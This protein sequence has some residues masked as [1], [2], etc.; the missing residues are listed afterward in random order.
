M[1]RPPCARRNDSDDVGRRR[2]LCYRS[3]RAAV[4]LEVIKRL[5]I[6]RQQSSVGQG[7]KWSPTTPYPAGLT[8]FLTTFGATGNLSWG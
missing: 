5:P 1:V 3:A 6:S 2:A 7:R 4:V 8:V